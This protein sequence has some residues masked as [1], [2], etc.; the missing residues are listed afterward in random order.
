MQSAGTRNKILVKFIGALFKSE[1][2]R[3]EILHLLRV[4]EVFNEKSKQT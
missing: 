3:C 2:L 4:I 1:K